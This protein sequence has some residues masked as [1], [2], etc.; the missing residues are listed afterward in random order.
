[1]ELRA[2]SKV[3]WNPKQIPR[4][5]C[6]CSAQNLLPLHTHCCTKCSTFESKYLYK[7]CCTPGA[8]CC[9]ALLCYACVVI[10]T[11]SKPGVSPCPGHL[12][13]IQPIHLGATWEKKRVVFGPANRFSSY[14]KPLNSFHLNWPTN[15]IARKDGKRWK[16]SCDVCRLM[17]AD[18]SLH[19]CCICSTFLHCVF[20][21]AWSNARAS[22][23]AKRVDPQEGQFDQEEQHLEE[24][25]QIGKEDH[26]VSEAG[27]FRSWGQQWSTS[28]NSR[29]RGGENF[30]WRR[31]G[32]SWEGEEG[33]A[34]EGTFKL[35]R[36]RVGQ[37]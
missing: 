31:D 3:I 19:T 35:H 25:D 15:K 34:T 36:G 13:F 4:K 20:S 16:L 23:A 11:E 18:M 27:Q 29:T 26:P 14:L 37:P 12:T 32:E 30:T 17:D 6:F 22:T 8:S 33:S 5:S 1:M 7:C 9:V 24:L 28:P 10:S 21:D 2:K